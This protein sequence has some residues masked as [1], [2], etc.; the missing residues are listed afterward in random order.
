[1]NTSKTMTLSQSFLMFG[2]I[3]ITLSIFHLIRARSLQEFP[4]S[5]FFISCIIGAIM[6]I[7]GL[8]IKKPKK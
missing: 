4:W 2:L 5:I 3:L 8:R 7:V 1:M 6:L